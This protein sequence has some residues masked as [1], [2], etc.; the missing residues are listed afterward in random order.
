M[1]KKISKKIDHI[2]RKLEKIKG[3]SVYSLL[4]KVLTEKLDRLVN[5]L[6]VAKIG[7]I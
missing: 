4:E 3:I 5:D 6:F 1:T 2:T 7:K